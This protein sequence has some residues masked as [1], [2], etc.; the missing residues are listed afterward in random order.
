MLELAAIIVFGIFAQWIAWRMRIPAIFPLIILGLFLGPF[1]T[2]FDKQWIDP[3]NIFAGK[4]MYYFVSLSV[5]VILFEGGL[6][7]KFKEVRQIAGVVRNLLIL[8]SVIMLV[9]GA[10]AAHYF[11]NMDYR[12]GL[13]FGSLII[14]TGPTVIAPILQSVRPNR[15]V[16]TVLKWEGI[17]IDPIGALVA[18]LVY[19]LLFVATN[20]CRR[21]SRRWTYSNGIKNLLFDCLCG[22]LFW[23]VFWVGFKYITS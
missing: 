21:P 17:V 4:T 2:L 7:L 13:L 3:E 9:G 11:L 22:F 6:T 8:G 1:S 23:V 12:V 15:N 10:F 14:V 18:V 19:E 16:S 20:G 5:G